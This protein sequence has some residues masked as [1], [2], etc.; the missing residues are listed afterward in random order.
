MR[1]GV[2]VLFA[3]ST[4]ACSD[5]DGAGGSPSTGG[6]GGA[7]GSGGGGAV[8]GSG[9]SGGGG[10]SASIDPCEVLTLDALPMNEAGPFGI[11]RHDLADDFE[12]PMVDGSTWRLSEHWSGCESYVF[13]P[14]GR[15][16]SGLDDTSIWERDV[17]Q[18]IEDSPRNAHYFFVTSRS[19]EVAQAER[20]AMQPRIDAALSALDP[21]SQ[22]WWRDR[23]HLVAQHRSDIEGWVGDLLSGDGGIGFAIDRQQRIRLM[24]SFADVR[25]YKAALASA[26]EWPWEA[27]M[28]YA[29]NEVRLYEFEAG[30][31]QYLAAQSDVTILTPWD[32]EVVAGAVEKT[33]DFPSAV[34]MADFD[35][36]EIDLTMDCEDPALG[37]FGNCPPWDYLSHIYL[38]DEV[39]Q[40]WLEL[41]RFITTYHRE[42]RYLVDATPMLVHLRD[43]GP[44]QIRYDASSQSYLSTLQFRLS[45]Q[46]KPS[47]PSEAT[48]LFAGGSFNSTYNDGYQ[49]V[50]V[51]IPATATKVELWALI[52]GHGHSNTTENCAEFCN[53]QHE[54]TVN[55]TPHTEEHPLAATNEGCMEQ[56]DQGTVPNQG[57]TWWFGRG[58]WCPGKEVQPW[59]EDVTADVTPGQIAT[60]SYQG[61]L[62]GQTPP[63]NA[64]NIVM[65]SYLVV[66]E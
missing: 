18:L 15:V 34:E 11:L 7:G 39:D 26:G 58:G 52:T 12:L 21:D 8:G 50:D 19:P 6:A 13:I 46:G 41:A 14:S 44:R 17:D 9:G 36:L 62:G 30:R 40:S 59:V 33:V 61:L 56:V 49:P 10:G 1:L 25:R 60:V 29:A 54:F 45:N 65:T 35:T 55:G 22:S 64:G 3:L 57:G 47:S 37:E 5:D 31:E 48:F 43:G 32:H 4:V 38:F 2:I 23:L 27:N 24:G 42:G 20:D 63:D 53:H 66:Y 51:L 28:A 16:N